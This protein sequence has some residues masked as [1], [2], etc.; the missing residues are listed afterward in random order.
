MDYT[1][2]INKIFFN[3][4]S[5]NELYTYSVIGTTISN[6]EFNWTSTSAISAYNYTL[7]YATYPSMDT[8][9]SFKSGSLNVTASNF[10]ESNVSN[11]LKF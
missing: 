10:I 3:L 11:S 9:I 4:L 8:W 1:Y 5:F 2:E 6:V 7:S